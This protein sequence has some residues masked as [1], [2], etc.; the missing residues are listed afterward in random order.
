[1]LQKGA[2]PRHRMAKNTRQNAPIRLLVG[3][4][5]AMKFPIRPGKI[6]GSVLRDACRGICHVSASDL[7][8]VSG[9]LNAHFGLEMGQVVLLKLA[10]CRV[11]TGCFH[12]G[13]A[14]IAL[15]FSIISQP[16]KALLTT[17]SQGAGVLEDVTDS[18][19]PTIRLVHRFCD[20]GKCDLQKQMLKV[21][22]T[23]GQKQCK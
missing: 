8:L 19:S 10:L 5:L 6:L 3:F 21:G 17:C 16:G 12:I 13:Q 1:M 4:V 20:L 14:L 15:Q 18:S 11:C 22:L 9:T 7:I 23:K 2:N